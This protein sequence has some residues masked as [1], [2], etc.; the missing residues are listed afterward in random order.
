MFVYC[1][2]I[3]SRVQNNNGTFVL[4]AKL[5]GKKEAMKQEIWNMSILYLKKNSHY[6]FLL[7]AFHHIN[8]EKI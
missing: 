3:I 6:Y 8:Y 4:T 5:S 2:F 1:N 7:N